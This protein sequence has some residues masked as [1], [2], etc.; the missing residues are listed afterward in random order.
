MPLQAGD[1]VRTDDG[2]EGKVMLLNKDGTSVLIEVHHEMR[3]PSIVR[4]YLSQLTLIKSGPP[5]NRKR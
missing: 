1:Q 3:G 2:H 5:D 4:Y